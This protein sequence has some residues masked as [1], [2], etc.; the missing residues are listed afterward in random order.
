VLTQRYALIQSGGYYFWDPLAAAILTDESLT[1]IQLQALS[2]IETEGPD[3]GRTQPSAGGAAVRVAVSAT[4]TR[5]EQL[6]LST[7]ND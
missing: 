5:F 6:F 3:S 1:T 7:L 2:I 4:R